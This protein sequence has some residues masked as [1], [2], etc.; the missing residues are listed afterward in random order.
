M[1]TSH[2][3]SKPDR[4]YALGVK[5]SATAAVV[6][7][8][9]VACSQ[10]DDPDDGS[11]DG[12]RSPCSTGAPYDLQKLQPL[13]GNEPS[14]EAPECIARCGVQKAQ[15][16]HYGVT[17][18]VAALP[19]G[20]CSY[21]GE[22]CSMR[23]VRTLDCDDGRTVACSLTGYACRCESGSWK[24]YHG[25]QG[26]SACI[27]SLPSAADGGIDAADDAGTK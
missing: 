5:L 1:P 24:C 17:W 8:V 26:A 4:C 27:C 3:E 18:S 11:Y 2:G 15:L 22:V 16:G 6:V 10:A 21:D 14:S 12:P 13:P 7:A 23:A 19:S 25:A 9:L 20:A